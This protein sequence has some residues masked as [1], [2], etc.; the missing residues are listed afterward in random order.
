[1]H[2]QLLSNKNRKKKTIKTTKIKKSVEI[3]SFIIF[4]IITLLDTI[5]INYSTSINLI[6][7]T[8][9]LKVLTLYIV[10]ILSNAT[11]KKLIIKKRIKLLIKN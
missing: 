8:I 10:L 9:R 2:L 4:D 1:M 5:V 3:K 6:S 11:N 7:Y